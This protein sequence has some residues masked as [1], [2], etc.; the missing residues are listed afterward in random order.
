LE[1]KGKRSMSCSL[2]QHL[3][4]GGDL[5]GGRKIARTTERGRERERERDLTQVL[6]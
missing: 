1:K 2:L 4:E 3:N 5:E 6:H